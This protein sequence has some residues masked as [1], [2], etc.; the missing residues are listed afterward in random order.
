MKDGKNTPAEIATGFMVIY[1]LV[2]SIIGFFKL[3]GR[4]LNLMDSCPGLTKGFESATPT[5]RDRLLNFIG[6]VV[7]VIFCLVGALVWGLYIAPAIGA[8]GELPKEMLE[9]LI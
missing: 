4:T 6:L 2:V 8:P 3:L 9:M 1:L 7:T 5:W